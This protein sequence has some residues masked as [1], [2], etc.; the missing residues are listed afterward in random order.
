[1]Q[2]QHGKNN[3]QQYI[4]GDFVLKNNGILLFKNKEYH[5]PPKELGVIILL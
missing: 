5:I 1:M 3:T 2:L 4:F